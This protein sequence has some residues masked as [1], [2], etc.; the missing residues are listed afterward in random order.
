[1]TP[2][3]L[4]CTLT[5]SYRLSTNTTRTDASSLREHVFISY[6]RLCSR[7]VRTVLC[8]CLPNAREALGR[9]GAGAQATMK[10]TAFVF[11]GRALTGETAAVPAPHR[12]APDGSPGRLILK[13]TAQS[14]SN[15]ARCEAAVFNFVKQ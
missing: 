1:M 2:R 7:G 13:T 10:A 12:G 4:S 6:E 5:A 8:D 9:L 14:E 3:T 11:H 15:A